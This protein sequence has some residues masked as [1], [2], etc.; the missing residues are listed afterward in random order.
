MKQVNIRK[1]SLAVFVSALLPV[2]FNQCGE[3]SFSQPPLGDNQ[4]QG[5]ITDT[6][7]G[8]KIFQINHVFSSSKTKPVDVIWVVDNSGSMS[9]E[10]S[11]VKA[12]I[13]SFA[14]KISNA[15]D[16]TLSLISATSGANSVD[17]PAI[18]VPN[19]KI[20]KLVGSTDGLEL[21]SA[22][23]CSPDSPYETCAQFRSDTTIF[24]RLRTFLRPEARK[25]V[26]MVTDDESRLEPSTFLQIFANAFKTEDLTVF[27]WIGLSR[28][29][30]P[31]QARE[32]VR[33]KELAQS[34]GGRVF[35]VCDQDWSANFDALASNIVTL[36]SPTVPLPFEILTAEILS[37]TVNGQV[38][39]P[40][41]YM[42]SASGINFDPSIFGGLGTGVI[43]IEFR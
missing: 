5:S 34:T 39:S 19:L 36:T 23:L 24:G 43:G 35:N 16:M 42:L 9:T 21:L 18:N 10:S 26:V 7:L 41:S 14:Q 40:N 33:Y 37:V 32:G 12:N 2:A 27:G 8:T 22:A 4:T 38:V 1:V 30:S 31:C 6:P 17:Y 29:Q 28:V 3:V 25:V 13:V 20:N 11:H 15:A